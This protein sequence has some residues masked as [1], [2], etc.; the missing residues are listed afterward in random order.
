MK[1]ENPNHVRR[2]KSPPVEAEM[3]QQGLRILARMIAG[4][5][6]RDIEAKYQIDR[7][8]DGQIL[9]ELQVINPETKTNRAREG[10]Q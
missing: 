6:V 5:Y 10:A 7:Q 8:P 4:R 2:G 1:G 3:L 9:P